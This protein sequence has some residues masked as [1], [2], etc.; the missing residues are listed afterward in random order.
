MYLST[1]NKQTI[2]LSS[3]IAEITQLG[4]KGERHPAVLPESFHADYTY[5]HNFRFDGITI[6][7]TILLSRLLVYVIL[8]N[9]SLPYSRWLK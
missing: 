7:N 3:N 1:N 5:M 4:Y 6:L 2:K 9:L 8:F